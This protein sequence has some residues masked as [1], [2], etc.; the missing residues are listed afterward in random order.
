MAPPSALG[1]LDAWG[2]LADVCRVQCQGA[3]GGL[4]TALL[5]PFS[6]KR[7][8]EIASERQPKSIQEQQAPPPLE[9]SEANSC[10][11]GQEPQEVPGG[12]GNTWHP[13]PQQEKGTNRKTGQG[14]AGGQREF[15]DRP[16]VSHG[17][18]PPQGRI[19]WRCLVETPL[20]PSHNI[21]FSWIGSAHRGL[22][23]FIY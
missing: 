17:A 19:G 23:S 8:A 13:G 21:T 7:S 22:S 9:P 6:L 11:L 16:R 10:G 18:P 14:A 5:A 12:R 2:T 4:R 20:K 3:Q 15:R 1:I